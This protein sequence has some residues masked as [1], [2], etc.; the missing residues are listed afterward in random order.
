[1]D[2]VGERPGDWKSLEAVARVVLGHQL[3]DVV[4]RVALIFLSHTDGVAPVPPNLAPVAKVISDTCR[5]PS[6]A[7]NL[8]A[9]GARDAARSEMV[10][11]AG[12]KTAPAPAKS[13]S[14]P[15]AGPVASA[16]GA[17]R[18]STCRC[19]SSRV[20]LER[21][22][23]QRAMAWGSSGDSSDV[24][25]AAAVTASS[26]VTCNKQVGTSDLRCLL[27]SVH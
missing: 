5:P 15:G 19:R 16:G 23:E 17:K 3:D 22:S 9:R 6:R 8:F 20:Q 1:M 25:K 13:R 4:H 24:V 27:C 7:A 21:L 14:A 18:N 11:P 26:P 2:L 10:I 12:K